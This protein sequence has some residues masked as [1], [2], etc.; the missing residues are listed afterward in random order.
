M[1]HVCETDHCE[2]DVG[3]L[4]RRSV[5][6]A[7]ACD[8]DHLARLGDLAVDDAL[9]QGVLVGGRGACQNAQLGPH[10][11]EQ[12]LLHLAVAVADAPVE[13]L[14]LDDEEVVARLHDAAL[15]R[16]GARCV[17]VVARHHAH[18]NS[19]PLALANRVGHLIATQS[20]IVSFC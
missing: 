8:G 3:L 5:V 9:D 12:V 18:R 17:D 14:A 1:K 15:H 4:E 16:D 2:S 13:L 7:V 6:G 20:R 11:V 19:G 10:L